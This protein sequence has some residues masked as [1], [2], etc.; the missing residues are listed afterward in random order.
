MTAF[1]VTDVFEDKHFAFAG[2]ITRYERDEIFVSMFSCKEGNYTHLHS[3]IVKGV[4]E[5]IKKIIYCGKDKEG[6][7]IMAAF[8]EHSLATIKFFKKKL[9]VV[10]IVG[11]LHEGDIQACIFFNRKVVTCCDRGEIKIT[12][13]MKKEIDA[14]VNSLTEMK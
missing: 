3:K 1:T 7:Q 2:K 6:A 5:P 13:V 10:S 9:T 8:T 12:R 14:S 11:S 4:S